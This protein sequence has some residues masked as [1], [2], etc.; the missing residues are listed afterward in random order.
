[1][2]NW[3][4]RLV[5]WLSPLWRRLGANTDQLEAIL[6]VKLTIDDRR[7]RAVFARQQKRKKPF[8]SGTIATVLTSLVMGG[9]YLFV[10]MVSKDNLTGLTLYFLMFMVLLSVT[11]ISDFTDVLIDVKDNYIILP[12]PVDAQTVLLARLLHILIHLSK[13]VLP[14]M[15]PGVVYLSIQ[16][17][18]IG[19]LLFCVDVALATLMCIFLINAVYLIILRIT[20]VERFKDI[21]GTVQVAFAILIFAMYYVGPRLAANLSVDKR[22]ILGH[23]YYY[24]AP[25]LWLAA[26]WEVLRHPVGQS[27]TLYGLAAAGLLL[28]V[29]FMW[30][31]MTF[32]APSF[33]KKLSGL[34]AGSASPS[35]SE[36]TLTGKAAPTRRRGVPVYRMVSSWIT[37]GNTEGTGFELAWLLTGRSRDF[38]LKVYPSFAYVLVY[39]F[40]Y[41]LQGKGQAT[42]AETWAHLPETKTYILLIYMCS[43]AMIT[44]ITNLVYSDKYKA[45]WVYYVSPMQTPGEILVGAVKAMLVKYF[46]PFYLGVSVFALWIWGVRVLPDL[47]LGLANVIWFGLLMGYV[48]LKRLPFSASISVQA[49]TGRFVKGFM[50]VIIPACVGFGHYLIRASLPNASWIIWVIFALSAILVWMIYSKYRELNWAELELASQDF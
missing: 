50:I 32:L 11:L 27:T 18:P 34:G 14:M 13:I 24:P 38:K 21:I 2:S 5:M 37:K 42:L 39:F 31:V 41:G 12:K 43:F 19:A 8:K 30:V 17:G 23:P 20:T 29:F 1:M 49:G 40:Y 36:K 22:L 9:F 33:D 7:P 4:L 44:A 16:T 46:V 47:F 26:L 15:L 10:F 35:P 28:P 3:I 25:P 45:S 48:R 6:W